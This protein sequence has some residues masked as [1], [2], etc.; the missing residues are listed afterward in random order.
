MDLTKPQL[1]MQSLAATMDF[2]RHF[3][4]QSLTHFR[5][6][7]AIITKGAHSNL[8]MVLQLIPLDSLFGSTCTYEGL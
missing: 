5:Y 7:W 6:S 1:V 8:H 3:A 2:V 4:L